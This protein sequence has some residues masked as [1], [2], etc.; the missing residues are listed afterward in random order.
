MSFTMSPSAYAD[1]L[2]DVRWMAATGECLDGAARRLGMTR[3]ALEKWLGR[4]D[5]A[6]LSA[7]IARQP[8]DHNRLVGDISIYELTG[9]GPRVKARRAR[10]RQTNQTRT[11]A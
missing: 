7:L 1:R 9:L 11:A 6:A 4:R 8:R 2:E 3:N 5:P 10:R